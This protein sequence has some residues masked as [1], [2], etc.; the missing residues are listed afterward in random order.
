MVLFFIRNWRKFVS[1][2]LISSHN[3]LFLVYEVGGGQQT[4][5]KKYEIK[6]HRAIV[7]P[8]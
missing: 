8:H 4:K 2:R 5:D 3:L 6:A 1:D 7:C